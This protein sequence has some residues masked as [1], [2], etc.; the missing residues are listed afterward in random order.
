MSN[1][2]VAHFLDGRILK[3][4][5]LDVDPNRPTCHIRTSASEMV[6]VRLDEMKALYFVKSLE[7][8]RTHKDASKPEPGDV[9]LHGVRQIEITFKD[10]EKMVGLTHH[11][12]PTRNFFFVLPID[13][14][15]NTIRLLVN[16][17]AVTRIDAV[18]NAA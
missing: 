12:P 9:R 14:Q 2:V 15:T 6:P 3:G 8:N 18:P 1:I 17:F 13:P 10:G 5:S 16:R 7:G 11:Y 4:T